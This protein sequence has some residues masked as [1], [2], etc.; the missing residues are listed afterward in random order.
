VYDDDRESV[1]GFALLNTTV[2]KKIT[3]FLEAQAGVENML[4]YTNR[5]QMPNMFGRSY[6]INLNFK[7]ENKTK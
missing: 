2:S 5:L 4:N 6:F 7:L 1:N 3:G